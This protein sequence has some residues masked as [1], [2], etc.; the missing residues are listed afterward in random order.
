M[1][2]PQLPIL[3]VDD[4]P[5]A[6]TA[7]RMTL[8]AAGFL[9]L[10]FCE[11]S[12]KVAAVMDQEDIG[13][14]LLDLNMPHLGGEALLP[15]LR[16]RFPHVPVIIVTG[17]NEVETAVECMRAGA[18]DYLV[19]PVEETRMTASVARA[20]EMRRLQ[21]EYET[22]RD[23]V[24]GGELEHPEAFEA[25]ITRNSRMT[26]LFQ[27]AETVAGTDRPVL[28]TGESGVGKELMAQ[29]LHDLSGRTGRFVAVNAAGLDDTVFSDTLFG[30]AR[31]AFTGAD[32]VRKGLVEQ[33]G[34]GTL[35]LDEIGDLAPQSQIKL[36]RL[37]Q[38]REYLP[39]GADMPKASTARILVAT[40]QSPADLRNSKAFRMDLLY[41]LQTH[42]I[43][44]PPLRERQEDIPLLLD[45][46]LEKAARD[47]NKPKPTPP[48]QLAEHL[49]LHPFPGN[50]REL[51]A[52]VFDAVSHHKNRMLSMERFHALI[53]LSLP[54]PA[55]EPE[56]AQR[57]NPFA[58]LE[59]LPSLKESGQM[60]ID[61][62]LLRANGNQSAAARLL[63]MTPS[64]LSKALKRAEK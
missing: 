43:H 52:M 8:E 38:E 36:L 2:T 49:A 24:L 28:I 42:A 46:F 20:L 56:S 10:R 25:M 34:E 32:T 39:L 40:N 6:L 35:F 29:A 59:P 13:L 53:G 17:Y 47:L 15:L 62:A 1:G 50:V 61:E 11:D 3:V 27:Y 55:K 7:C 63:G 54:D 60:L 41:R 58:G 26:S 33:A 57:D 12:R 19:K 14:V 23:K 5:Q 45:H 37:L 31:G 22:F 16:E 64:G 30:H 44:I 51:E 9:D 21:A 18:M 48:P 4:E